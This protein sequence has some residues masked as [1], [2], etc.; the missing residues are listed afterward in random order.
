M[1]PREAPSRFTDDGALTRMMPSTSP[2]HDVAPQRSLLS[3]HLA[4]A[5][6]GDDSG[7]VL[8]DA[9]LDQVLRATAAAAAASPSGRPAR[10]A[11]AGDARAE[12][13]A[14]KV[15]P[16]RRVNGEADGRSSQVATRDGTR[17][18]HESSGAVSAATRSGSGQHAVH[19]QSPSGTPRCRRAGADAPPSGRSQFP[20][21]RAT[22]GDVRGG[23]GG[24]ARAR[25]GCER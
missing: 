17:A 24:G 18:A 2:H 11:A 15:P 12:E 4:M 10:R 13:A 9:S 14:A 25:V 5:S 7:D 1:H 6:A 21:A 8:L 19:S 20:V 22:R 23:G 16:P 3:R